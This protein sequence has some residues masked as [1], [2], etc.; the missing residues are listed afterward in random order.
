MVY[1]LYTD[2]TM[3]VDL[4]EVE[5]RKLIVENKPEFIRERFF[6]ISLIDECGIKPVK[7]DFNA[8]SKK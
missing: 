4:L 1:T 7:S 2:E 8:L 6:L 5:E 3:F